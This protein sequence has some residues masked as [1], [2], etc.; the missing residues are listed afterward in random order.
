MWQM[1]QQEQPEDL[2]IATGK[3]VSLKYFVER[4]FAVFGLDWTQHVSSDNSLL[5]PSDIRYGAANP[6]RALYK[7]GWRSTRGIDDVVDALC[8]SARD[9]LNTTKP[10]GESSP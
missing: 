4:V 2:V 1:V 10:S 8:H 6:A 5:R 7:L 3:T 9:A